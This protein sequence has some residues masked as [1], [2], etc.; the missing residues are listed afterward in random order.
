ML[1]AWRGARRFIAP[2]SFGFPS[3]L[4]AY[5]DLFYRVGFGDSTFITRGIGDVQ[6]EVA[7]QYLLQYGSDIVNLTQAQ[8]M[9]LLGDPAVKLFGTA[10]PDYAT[11]DASVSL[12]SLDGKSV[13]AL[14]DSLAIHVIVKNF[15]AAKGL[16]LPVR[17]TRT[18]NDN[19]SVSSDSLF[20]APLYQDTLG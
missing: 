15:G 20:A 6:K 13:T 17:V 1:G 14:S 18:F 16:A 2:S 8:Q 11:D 5:S 4:N 9:M 19:S 12:H 7:R 10:T 3:T